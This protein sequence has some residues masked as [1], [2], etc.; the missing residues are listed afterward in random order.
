MTIFRS[1]GFDS[2]IGTE[3][4]LWGDLFIAR[5][6]TFVIDGKMNGH[7]KITVLV[8]GDTKPDTKT[9]LRVNGEVWP[10]SPDRPLEINVHNVVITGKVTCDTIHVEG[11]LAIRSGANLKADKI[12]YR[13]LVIETGAV[14]HGQMYHLDHVSHGEQV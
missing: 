11:T 7:N 5:N 13:E 4:Q 8:D 14:V 9:T 2:L 6:S 12:F 3:T 10:T 1:R